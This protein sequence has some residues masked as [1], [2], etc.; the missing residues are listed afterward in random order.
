MHL[1]KS[2]IK[3]KFTCVFLLL[4]V[5]TRK[6]RVTCV[7]HIVFSFDSVIVKCVY[8]IVFLPSLKSYSDFP[9]HKIKLHTSV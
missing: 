3:I 7:I 9:R 5:A 6:C 8:Q 2:S 4:N 1:E